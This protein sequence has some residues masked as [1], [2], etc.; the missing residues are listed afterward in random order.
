MVARRAQHLAIVEQARVDQLRRRV[1]TDRRDRAYLIG[2]EARRHVGFARETQLISANAE[3]VSCLVQVESIRG[4]DNRESVAARGMKNNRLRRL[5]CRQVHSPR[6]RRGRLAMS[7]FDHIEAHAVIAEVLLQ[8]RATGSWHPT[9]DYSPIHSHAR[10]GGAGISSRSSPILSPAGT[11]PIA[12]SSDPPRLRNDQPM[13]ATPAKPGGLERL[14]VQC[15]E[16]GPV[17][18]AL[19]S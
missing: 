13:S 1:W 14:P 11:R 18:S 12:P 10:A 7:V 15:G 6:L 5:L 8:L 4:R 9:S 2:R 19:R 17:R 3:R 16:L